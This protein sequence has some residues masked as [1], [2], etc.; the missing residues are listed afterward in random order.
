MPA[1]PKPAP[2]S[3][4]SWTLWLVGLLCLLLA[5]AIFALGCKFHY[6]VQQWLRG[7]GLPYDL[8]ESWFGPPTALA[9][10]GAM[11]FI[12]RAAYADIVSKLPTIPRRIVI[13][14]FVFLPG[15]IVMATLIPAIAARI[16]AST[17]W[18]DAGRQFAQ[19]KGWFNEYGMVLIV[20]LLA[21]IAVLLAIIVARLR[22]KPTAKD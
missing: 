11:T 19:A 12:G 14:I 17:L 2:K 5:V 4:I 22:S 15:L 16:G 8:A 18:R 3:G 10:F 1:D 13:F 7:L 20:A 6:P 9:L 21:V